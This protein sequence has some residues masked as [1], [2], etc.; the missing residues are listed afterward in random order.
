MQGVPPPVRAL[1]SLRG[2]IGRLTGWGAGMAA[3]LITTL[4]LGLVAGRAFQLNIVWIP[5]TT[6]IVLIWGV[7][8]GAVSASCGREHFKLEL[9]GAGDENRP[10]AFDILR[11]GVALALFVYVAIGGYPTIASTAMQS[12]ASI[13]LSYS[14]MRMAVVGGVAM[15][16]VVEL[17]IL[18]EQVTLFGRV[19]AARGEVR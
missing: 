19:H 14:V 4:L 7:A 10:T 8:L 9:F 12:F 6:R 1:R 16:A 18:L 5:E 17:L 13:P 15:M 2:W 3:F 11:T